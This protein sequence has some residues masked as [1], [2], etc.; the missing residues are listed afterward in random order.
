MEVK[1]KVIGA[2]GYKNPYSRR[3]KLPS[4]ITPILEDIEP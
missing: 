1:V 4:A 3:V 2:K